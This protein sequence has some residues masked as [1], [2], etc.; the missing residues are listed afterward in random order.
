MTSND[1]QSKKKNKKYKYCI[2]NR[3]KNSNLLAQENHRA[4]L[5]NHERPATYAQ[6]K[7]H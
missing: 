5:S 4:T 6:I 3:G 7:F 1:Y 2:W